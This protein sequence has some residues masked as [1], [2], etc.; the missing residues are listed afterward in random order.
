VTATSEV[1]ALLE[2]RNEHGSTIRCL[3]EAPDN[4]DP[5]APC[6]IVAPSY[7]LSM[8]HFGP[9]S[10]FLTRN[11]FRS[12]RFDYTNHV[13]A[14]DGVVYDYRLTTAATD[15]ST[16]VE[17]LGDW[18]IRRPVGIISVS[19]GARIAFRALRGRSDVACL[20]SLVGVVNLQDTLH[21]VTGEDVVATS[22]S[23]R[24]PHD[25]EVLGYELTGR[26]VDDAV[27]HNMHTLESTKDD[28]ARCRFPITHVFAEDDAWTSLEEVES[29]FCEDSDPAPRQLYILPEACHKLEYNPVAA[30]TAFSLAVCAMA[31][32]LT[33]A[34]LAVE[35]VV[36][37]SFN[38]V[39]DKH[40]QEKSLDGE[41]I[42]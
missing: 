17:A 33:G 40:R 8:R 1:G 24:T 32:E 22:L 11:G 9:L 19:M 35:Q 34:E 25:R 5:D 39:V 26:T 14:S 10:L 36:S 37:P 15:L 21:S 20:V 16:V 18:G 4:G 2:T 7:A 28:L 42:R 29:V 38:A 41:A 23:G 12:L 3:L 31:R 6:V 27:A 13:G 30:R